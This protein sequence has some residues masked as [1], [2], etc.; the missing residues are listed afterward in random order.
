MS[1]KVTLEKAVPTIPSY[2][3]KQKDLN[4]VSAYMNDLSNR[5]SIPKIHSKG[6]MISIISKTPEKLNDSPNTSKFIR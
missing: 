1:S 6:S 4:R 5:L 2:N 3:I